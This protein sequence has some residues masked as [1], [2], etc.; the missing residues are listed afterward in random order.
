M[1]SDG[2]L[3]AA[4]SIVDVAVRAAVLSGAPRR[5]VAAT[6][7]A[8]A[9]VVMVELRGRVGAR[10]D[11][12]ATLSASQKRRLKHKKKELDGITSSHRHIHRTLILL[13]HGI[14]SSSYSRR[15]CILSG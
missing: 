6:A 3:P 10:G 4:L 2:G 12:I 13:L 7:A 8:V 5:T 15:G 1:A 11:A 14:F 9:S